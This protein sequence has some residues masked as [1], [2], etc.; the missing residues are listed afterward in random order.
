MRKGEN[1]WE[2]AA[3]YA[4]ERQELALVLQYQG[5]YKAAGDINRQALDRREDVLGKERPNTLTSVSDLASAAR[6]K[7]PYSHDYKQ[8]SNTSSC[9]RLGAGF[10]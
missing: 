2:G 9:Y 6:R 8:H 7:H 4:N 5:K 3:L 10:I 1:S